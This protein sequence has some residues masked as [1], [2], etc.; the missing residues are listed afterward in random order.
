MKKFTCMLA[1]FIVASLCSTAYGAI[2]YTARETLSDWAVG[3]NNANTPTA[4]RVNGLVSGG[5]GYRK[6]SVAS[7]KIADLAVGIN[8]ATLTPP[9]VVGD[10]I[11]GGFYTVSTVVQTTN[12]D[13]TVSMECQT[14]ADLFASDDVTN[15][16]GIATTTVPFA[17]VPVGTAA[18]SIVLT[19]AVPNLI[20]TLVNGAATNT[21]AE[22]TVYIESIND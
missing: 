2:D 16:M 7:V 3:E 1:G 21:A 8:T 11:V 4:F 10:I 17:L 19:S 18:T 15:A 6:V 20:V 12:V 14:A 5:Y 22:V 9:L 13:A